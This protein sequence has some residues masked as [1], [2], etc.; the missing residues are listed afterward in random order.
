MFPYHTYICSSTVFTWHLSFT[1]RFVLFSTVVIL[2]GIIL[3]VLFAGIGI[4][5][6]LYLR[7]TCKLHIIL[8]TEPFVVFFC[9]DF[10]SYFS[11][12]ESDPNWLNQCT[13]R[14]DCNKSNVNEEAVLLLWLLKKAILFYI[15]WIPFLRPWLLR[16]HLCK[17]HTIFKEREICKILTVCLTVG[18]PQWR[19][20]TVYWFNML[21]LYHKSKY[22]LIAIQNNGSLSKQTGVI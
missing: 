15:R 7:G 3:A 4:A 8:N 20:F 10:F 22:T 14:R 6:T 1:K 21:I 13:C 5:M 11:S 17:P 16:S 12:K 9:F 2:F 19:Q 18:L